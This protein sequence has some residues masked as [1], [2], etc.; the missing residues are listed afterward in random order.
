[1]YCLVD[2]VEDEMFFDV[3]VMTI[4]IVAVLFVDREVI[5]MFE[6]LDLLYDHT[7]VG[8]KPIWLGQPQPFLAQP[9]N[10]PAKFFFNLAGPIMAAGP[11]L[12]FSPTLD[13]TF[14]H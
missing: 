2:V 14:H 5:L 11:F 10:G 3:L 13:H 7:S 6:R 8:E 4:M 12:G 1:M 9:K